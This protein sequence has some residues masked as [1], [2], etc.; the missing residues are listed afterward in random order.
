MKSKLPHLKIPVVRYYLVHLYT[1]FSLQS[2]PFTNIFASFAQT[3][4]SQLFLTEVS[5]FQ[6]KETKKTHRFNSKSSLPLDQ[7]ETVDTFTIELDNQSF[8]EMVVL[9]YKD[10]P[11]DSVLADLSE[12]LIES[13]EIIYL[14][15]KGAIYPGIHRL[16]MLIDSGITAMVPVREFLSRVLPDKLKINIL[17]EYQLMNFDEKPEDYIDFNLIWFLGKM[18]LPSVDKFLQEEELRQEQEPFLENAEEEKDSPEQ[19]ID[20]SSE[21]WKED[22]EAE[23]SESESEPD[24]V[25]RTIKIELENELKK[26]YLAEMRFFTRVVGVRHYDIN[27]DDLSES[28][29]VMLVPEP[30]N[31]HDPFAVSV[32]TAE[33]KMIGYLKKELSEIMYDEIRKGVLYRATVA[34]VLPEMLDSNSRVNLMI[35]K[36]MYHF[37]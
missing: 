7:F 15:A 11:G 32:Q 1:E 6:Q 17:A 4:Y 33:G 30:G 35:E 14:F 21:P 22:D 3:E 29:R 26:F 9:E 34:K 25:D 20:D 16:E 37:N 31:P 23:F 24:P 5:T 18:D 2:S 36:V 8:L 27:L 19:P 12:E 13:F 10:L 28:S